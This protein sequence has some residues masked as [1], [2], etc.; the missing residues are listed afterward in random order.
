LFIG[1]VPKTMLEDELKPMFIPFGNVMDVHI[2]RDHTSKA[3][4]GCAFV[5][6]ASK[7]ESEACMFG[8]HNKI[9]LPGMQRPLQVK[10]AGSEPSSASSSS[11]AG[12]G[13]FGGGLAPG[14]S[15]KLFIGMVPK[16]YSETDLRPIFEPF[17][18]IKDMNV[19]RGADGVSR[20]CAFIL[21]KEV[22]SAIQAITT[23]NGKIKLE[24]APNS[25]VVQFA[26]SS[27]KNK[28]SAAASQAASLQSFANPQLGLNN[29]FMFQ[30]QFVDPYTGL[31][32]SLGG[33]PSYMMPSLQ[34]TNPLGTMGGAGAPALGSNKEGPP[35]ANLFI[36]HLPKDYNDASLLAL[37]SQFGPVVSC[38]IITDKDTGDS[39]GFGFVSYES[40]DSAQLAIANTNGMQ[41]PGG[42]RLKV[43][44]KS[45]IQNAG[46]PY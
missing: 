35:G 18:E 15:H 41:L 16:T 33:Y 46:R 2:I 3:H 38:K 24:G 8:L 44:V 36:Y 34:A 6:F 12:L 19:L 14:A 42:K 30:Q 1:Q 31:P 7:E 5:T 26:S 45:G 39:K 10:Y 23:M 22:P 17:G 32:T 11:L 9:T 43:S 25:L 13:G 21:F 37:F 40:A 28:N 27:E 4:K 29:G 20:G